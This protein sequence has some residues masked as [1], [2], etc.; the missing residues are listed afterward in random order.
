[1]QRVAVL[2]KTVADNLFAGR[3]AVGEEIRLGKVTFEVIGVL[4]GKGPDLAGADQDDVIY[5]PMR[6]AL[7]RVFNLAYINNIFV[8][9]KGAAAIDRAVSEIG[10]ILRERHRLRGR[11]DDFTIQ[12]QSELVRTEEE[13]ARTFTQLLAAV[14][15]ISLL[16]GG[17]GILAVMLISIKE[18]TRE[19]GIRRAVGALRR[20]ILLQFLV[21]SF[22]LSISGGLVGVMLGVG[23]SVAASTFTQWPM[24]LSLPAIAVAFGF[25]A[26]IGVLFGVYPAAKAARLDPI[27]ALQ[28]E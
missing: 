4:T 13:T 14:A 5:I 15:G 11:P 17:V 26:C 2:G 3:S 16:V 1:M 6:T 12:S 28:A 21:E 9:A 24:R 8:Q 22:V 23:L 7:R 25:A 20:D 18:R 10:D 27:A 19:I